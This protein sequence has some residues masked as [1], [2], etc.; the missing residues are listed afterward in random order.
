MRQPRFAR[1]GV[2][3]A[4][5]LLPALSAFV[6]V[7]EL[8]RAADLYSQQK[9]EEAKQALADIDRDALNESE[10]GELD[11]LLDALNRTLAGI[12]K[13]NADF[14]AAEEAFS[15]QRW[16]AA[17]SL[18]SAVIDNMHAPADIRDQSLRKRTT[19][20]D[21][22]GKAAPRS[23]GPIL[24]MQPVSPGATTRAPQTVR[25]APTPAPATSSR[26]V[27]QTPPP[28]RPAPARPA[29]TG[30]MTPMSMEPATSSPPATYSAPA[31]TRTTDVS[32]GTALD[33]MQ[34]R[35]ELFWQR[36]LA[37][38]DSLAAEVREAMARNDY[39]E[40]RQLADRAVSE[41]DTAR[42]YAGSSAEYD[43]ARDRALALRDEIEAGSEI[44]TTNQTEQER[45]EIRDLIRI[46]MQEQEKQRADQIEQLFRTAE[47][48][49]KEQQFAREAETYRQIL[50]V[51]PS[52]SRARHYLEIAEDYASYWEQ[53]E[54]HNQLAVQQRR[55]LVNADQ[56]LIPWDYEVMYPRNWAEI[57][58]R[59]EAIGPGISGQSLEDIE[60]NRRLEQVLPEV[61]VEDQELER[62]LDF[63][64][65]QSEINF[66]VDWEDLE[67]NGI[68]RDVPV[69]L[70]LTQLPLRTV[71]N[72]IL[73]QVGG[74]VRLAFSVGESLL[75]IAT[76]DKLDRDK[77]VLVYDI[78]DLLVNVPRFTNA[79]QLDPAQALQ[80]LTQG[81][82]AGGV[83]G[84]GGGGGGGGQQLFQNTNQG[85]E[86]NED[87]ANLAEEIM[88][89]IRQTVEPDS[90]QETGGG[91][92]SVRELNGQLIV[93]NTSDSHR[94][95]Q[96]LLNQLRETRALQIAIEARYLSV[97]SNFL[98]EIGVDIDFVFNS[99]SAG[100]D[101]AFTPGGTPIVDPFTGSPV[102][103]PRTF[104]QIGSFA[105]VPGFGT[106]FTP[107]AT[108]VQPFGQAAFVP[109]GTGVS[110]HF[111][112]TTPVT[113][114]QGSLALTNPANFNTSVP[115]SFATSPSLV[116]AL[117]IAGTFLD[118]LQVD[119]LIRATQANSRSSIVQAPRILM[120][121]GQRANIT[122]GRARQYVATLNP[123]LAEGAVG[124]QPVP[125]VAQSGV[126]LDVEG[127]ISADRKYVTVTVRTTQSEEPDFE[128][129]EVQRQSGNSP[130]A[131]VTLLDQRFVTI[132]TTA[133][134][135][136]G[137]T[138]LLGGLKQVG[139]IEVEAGVPILNKIPVLK[140]AFTNSTVIKD[141]RTL[142]I[143]MKSKIL[144]QKE[145]EEEAFPTFAGGI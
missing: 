64:Q 31:P 97:T 54:W 13:A 81:G 94:R 72:E 92:A 80:G 8:D 145:Q 17:D 14:K 143:L 144:I 41:I 93:Y 142:L 109:S 40:A 59:R 51:D 37:L 6:Q 87:N 103:I 118:N 48:L 35:D 106:P 27:N 105:S 19:S 108:P 45:E 29:P 18:Y 34:A 77:L 32:R 112:N 104:S 56:A 36:A 16:S 135:P 131:F 67:A 39:D 88:D 68:E 49:R 139:E 110:P 70:K 71:L 47:Q 73:S 28:A 90:W 86:N 123:I 74:E 3:L 61:R 25:P 53:E 38:L 107:G 102:L 116:P 9:Y 133:S 98:E 30:T 21:M 96:D 136:D 134:I 83:G 44:Y 2:W 11:R 101:R 137:G 10:R 7:E 119:F 50:Y 99:G 125:A 76:K 60:L 100:F 84:G 75:R 120:F 65:D 26:T 124:F 52:N 129:F 43:A 5:L 126:S 57:A 111:N 130:G 114:Q 128:R 91:D 15:N 4:C 121:N 33:Q 62:V 22:M 1:R 66:S 122:V 113:A 78:R 23:S 85:Q 140:R 24:E 115:G 127:T 82:G 69:T 42:Q 20:R 58:S 12:E 95:V 89:I 138:I 63:L 46:R 141:T 117:N 55:S 79:A 132:N